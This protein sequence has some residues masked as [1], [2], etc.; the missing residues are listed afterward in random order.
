MWKT[1][2][3]VMDPDL[4]KQRLTAALIPIDFFATEDDSE[5]LTL[6]PMTEQLDG[7][8]ASKEYDHEFDHK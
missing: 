1:Q 4:L 5:K 2:L 3:Q 7:R 6:Y 8:L